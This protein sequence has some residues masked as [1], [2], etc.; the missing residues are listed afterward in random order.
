MKTIKVKYSYEIPE[1][2]TGIVEFEDGEKEW[3]KTGNLHR[4][5]GPARIRRTGTNT[6]YLNSLWIWDS[7]LGTFEFTDCI[8]LSKETHP[9][10][11]TV[12][13]WKYLNAETIKEQII[14]PGM[15]EWVIE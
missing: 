3:L 9:E 4:E 14:I 1:N 10:Y 2:Y 12:Q 15:E 5:D 8:I 13:V 6:W 7:I 11:P